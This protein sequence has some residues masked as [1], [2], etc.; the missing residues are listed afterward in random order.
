MRDFNSLFLINRNIFDVKEFF[1]NMEI[2]LNKTGLIS[3]DCR[4]P[5]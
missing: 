2:I 1:K 4:Y 5:L 3:Y